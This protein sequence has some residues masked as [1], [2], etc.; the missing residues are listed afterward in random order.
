MRRLAILIAF[1]AAAFGISTD[2]SAGTAVSF[3][4]VDSIRAATLAGIDL[5]A[6]DRF[7]SADSIFAWLMDAYPESPMGP[8][9]RAGN[10]QARMIDAES[11]DERESFLTLVA[12]AER[13]SDALIKSGGADAET[14]FALGVA[15]GYRA[16]H[17]SRWGGWF[18]ALKQGLR[19]K[20]HFQQALRIDSTL[21]DA[22]LGL[23]TYLYWKSVKTD[24]INWLPLVP[25]SRRRGMDHLARASHCG[26]FARAA[27]RAALAGAL[28]KDE[29]YNEAIAH[30]DTL[31]QEHSQ[32][33]TAWWIKGRAL[34]AMYEWDRAQSAFD[35][36][37][38]RIR[39]QGPG[40]YF[41]LIECA[42]YRAQCHWGAGRYRE[43]QSECGRAL[44]YPADEEVRKRQ[45]G[46]LDE[47]R[48]MQRRLAKMLAP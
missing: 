3:Y 30:A 38:A 2:A 20:K 7:A 42:Y 14:E 4:A 33:K 13:R 18:S 12:E 10:I 31:R 48:R 39:A 44:T 36:L 37:E 32:G 5:S 28:I 11:N 41:N 19:A 1:L 23:G 24:W 6:N 16:V 15:A 26:I 40:N 25:D 17:E 34:L 9:F 45:E 8:L 43:A 27:A 46:K 21:C 22:L 47:L 29:R 35:S